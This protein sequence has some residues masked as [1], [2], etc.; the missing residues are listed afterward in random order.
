MP[1]T[2]HPPP[3]LLAAADDDFDAYSHRDSVTSIKDDPFFRNYQSP[4]SVSLARELRS[5]TYSLQ[6]LRDED[7]EEEPPPRSTRR[8]SADTS[9]SVNLP[10]RRPC[11][12]EREN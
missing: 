6:D 3:K 9:N 1:V 10:V 7:A 5:A 12:R 4:H 2:G 8:P 11:P